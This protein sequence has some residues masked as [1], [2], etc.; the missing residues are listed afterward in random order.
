MTMSSDILSWLREGDAFARE[1]G[2]RL[3]DANAQVSKTMMTVGDHH[4][5]AGGVCQGGALF[6]LADLALAGVMNAA[7][8]LT[9]SLQTAV[10]FHS[11]AH[12]GDILT[13]TAKV[14]QEHHRVPSYEV[15]IRDQNEK[16]VATFTAIA[17]RKQKTIITP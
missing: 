13:A 17:Y 16:L 12:L 1:N 6:T 4:L 7:G 14:K 8:M 15:E 2:M 5:N 11:P 3:L 10:V 9:V